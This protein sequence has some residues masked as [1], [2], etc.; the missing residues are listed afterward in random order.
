MNSENM[1]L[2][3][4]IDLLVFKKEMIPEL[5]KFV[6]LEKLAMS[7][8]NSDS[9]NT[10]TFHET[11][12]K[13]LII[14]YKDT[15]PHFN[16]VLRSR[17]IFYFE[18]DGYVFDE[19]NFYKMIR[20]SRKPNTHLL[21]ALLDILLRGYLDDS[22][23]QYSMVNPL[24][25]FLDDDLISSAHRYIRFCIAVSTIRN[26]EF[27]AYEI[28][29]GNATIRS[30]TT[31][32][33]SLITFIL[34]RKIYL[35]EYIHHDFSSKDDFDMEDDYYNSILSELYAP[36]PWELPKHTLSSFEAFNHLMS[37]GK[38]LPEAQ[39]F[40]TDELIIW[41]NTYLNE[42][43][44]SQDLYFHQI[45]FL[46][47]FASEKALACYVD[48]IPSHNLSISSSDIAKYYADIRHILEL[49]LIADNSPIETI[50][51]RQ[52]HHEELIKTYMN[53]NLPNWLLFTLCHLTNKQLQTAK[54]LYITL[55]LRKRYHH[56]KDNDS[57]PS[58]VLELLHKEIPD[59]DS[60]YNICSKR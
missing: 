52:F 29:G 38:N 22:N 32:D 17:F 20:G 13:K 30:L 2:C 47:S 48:F 10:S 33:L 51:L 45:L 57:F 19:S 41:L 18:N 4:G 15:C 46:L 25:D 44:G 59:I 7:L 28:S 6:L 58:D 11:D 24:E 1:Q 42:Y 50:N 16:S 37:E 14:F 26:E 39:P 36:M 9:Y 53:L 23:G 27:Q 55:V 21:N 54:Y 60:L 12:T 3:T 5:E 56:Q 34:N 35:S 8:D 40:M 49:P 43:Y 31:N